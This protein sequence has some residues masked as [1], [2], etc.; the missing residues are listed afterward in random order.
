MNLDEIKCTCE[1]LEIPE[2]I[3]I[4]CQMDDMRILKKILFGSA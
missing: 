3:P 4:A 2:G 1:R